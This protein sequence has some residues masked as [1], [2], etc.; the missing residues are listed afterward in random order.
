MIIADAVARRAYATNLVLV[1]DTKTNKFSQTD[2]F[3]VVQNCAFGGVVGNYLFR[4]GGENDYECRAGVPMGRHNRVVY[5]AEIEIPDH[6][7]QP[8]DDLVRARTLKEKTR[9]RY[10]EAIPLHDI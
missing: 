5:A 3:P 2:S 8:F 4:L 10:A 7:D 9:Q 6:D 1:Y